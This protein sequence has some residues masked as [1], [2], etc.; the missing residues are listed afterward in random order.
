MTNIDDIKAEAV[1]FFETFLTHEPDDI[2]IL[3]VENLQNIVSFRCSSQDKEQLLKEVTPDEI[4]K[5]LYSM[6]N[7][8]SPGLMDTLVSFSKRLGIS[9]VMTSR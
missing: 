1:R 8:K 3:S 6:P 5:I 7:N 2:E 4:K 9:L